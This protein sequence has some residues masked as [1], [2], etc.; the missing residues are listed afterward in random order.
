MVIGWHKTIEARIAELERKVNEGA[1]H[2]NSIR[3][4]CERIQQQARELLRVINIVRDMLRN[5]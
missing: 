3:A 4:D 5:G 2:M 1:A